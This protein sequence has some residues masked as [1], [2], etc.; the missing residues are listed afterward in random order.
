MNE[1]N[2]SYVK[3]SQ[4]DPVFSDLRKTGGGQG[5]TFPQ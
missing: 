5:I 1:D 4:G 3:T 2:D